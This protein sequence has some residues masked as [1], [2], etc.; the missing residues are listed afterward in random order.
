MEMF[1]MEWARHSKGKKTSLI[2]ICKVHIIV[3]NQD[4]NGILATAFDHLLS[5][6]HAAVMCRWTNTDF[7][8]LHRPIVYRNQISNEIIFDNQTF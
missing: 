7:F 1:Q 6:F 4:E 3:F 2:S 8:V 5:K